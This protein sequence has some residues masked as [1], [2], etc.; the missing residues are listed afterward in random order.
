MVVRSTRSLP[1]YRV[2][3]RSSGSDRGYSRSW[4]PS[5]K[6]RPGWAGSRDREDTELRDY[7]TTKIKELKDSG[8]LY[9]LQE[10][11]FGFRM[12]IPDTG[13]IPPGGI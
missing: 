11:W 3:Q 9:E 7:L 6:K 1:C 4:D 8:K 5:S 10:K 12:E 13:Y 2:S